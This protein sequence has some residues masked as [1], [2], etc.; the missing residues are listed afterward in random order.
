MIDVSEGVRVMVGSH[1]WKEVD[2]RIGGLAYVTI[3]D[4]VRDPAW[5]SSWDRIWDRIH[6]SI[7]SNVVWH[8]EV[9][10]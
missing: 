1:V 4:G 5:Q 8:P 3:Y 9:D 10:E 6:R 2:P 7:G